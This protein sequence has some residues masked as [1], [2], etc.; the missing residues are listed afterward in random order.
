MRLPFTTGQTRKSAGDSMESK[1]VKGTVSAINLRAH[2]RLHPQHI[3][4]VSSLMP[5]R[6]ERKDRQSTSPRV[7]GLWPRCGCYLKF[8]GHRQALGIPR[9]RREHMFTDATA[10]SPVGRSVPGTRIF[11]PTIGVGTT[12]HRQHGLILLRVGGLS[13]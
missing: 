13:P 6:R 1:L 12:N 7:Q 8:P 2:Q 9:S 11:R 3:T 10:G 4:E 5:V